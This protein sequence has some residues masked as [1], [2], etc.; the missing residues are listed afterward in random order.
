[1]SVERVI[2][3]Q[4]QQQQKTPHTSRLGIRTQS[5]DTILFSYRRR[6]QQTT[7]TTR[8][9]QKHKERAA[10]DEPPRAKKK[11]EEEEEKQGTSRVYLFLFERGGGQ[12]L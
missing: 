10:R 12:H 4:Q 8:E 9:V 5:I 11:A 1:L 3:Q 2:P 7:T 6:R